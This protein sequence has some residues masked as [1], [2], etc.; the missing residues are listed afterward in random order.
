MF[1]EEKDLLNHLK[2]LN[3]TFGT[4][5]NTR[6]NLS[7]YHKVLSRVMLE[8]EEPQSITEPVEDFETSV[9]EAP[10]HIDKSILR[11]EKEDLGVEEESI[12]VQESEEA[13]IPEDL[14]EDEQTKEEISHEHEVDLEEKI[15]SE[16]EETIELEP[17]SEEQVSNEED[18]HVLT[19]NG[20]DGGN[21][22]EETE[23]VATESIDEDKKDDAKFNLEP[24]DPEDESLFSNLFSQ[25]G[26]ESE[27]DKKET[28][29][30]GTTEEIVLP[31]DDVEIKAPKKFRIR[32]KD[33]SKIEPLYDDEDSELEEKIDLFKKFAPLSEDMYDT[34]KTLETNLVE[35]DSERVSFFGKDEIEDEEVKNS[36]EEQETDNE[37]NK[38]NQA[39]EESIVIDFP[40]K[41]K[42]EETELEKTV[43]SLNPAE[44]ESIVIS[45]P[46]EKKVEETELEKTSEPIHEDDTTQKDF[47]KLIEEQQNLFSEPELDEGNHEINLVDYESEASQKLDEKIA[48]EKNN[49]SEESRLDVLKQN[50]IEGKET[51]PKVDL[52]EILERKEM[53]KI[54]EVLFDYDIEDFA[55]ILDAISKCQ[56]ADDAQ[57]IIDQVSKERHINR[58]SKELTTFRAIIAEYYEKG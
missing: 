5:E 53:T 28:G 23:N 16:I 19:F 49:I 26:G 2:V 47:R 32:I 11:E 27:N 8:K 7:D 52:A 18:D 3:E 35:N 22:L 25:V 14:V 45:Y 17:S 37:E 21:I 56:N 10:V 44:E 55:G 15:P 6:F 4:D 43:E 34:D 48:E 46:L 40:V 30:T 51:P 54:I 36:N 24:I 12:E 42:V 13:A 57:L 38:I 41:K 39:D 9:I 58:N 29:E 20:F 1:L 50:F 31:D 33:N